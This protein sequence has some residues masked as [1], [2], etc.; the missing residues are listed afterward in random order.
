[1]SKSPSRHSKL[2]RTVLSACVAFGVRTMSP[3]SA[4]MSRPIASLNSRATPRG[5]C[6][7]AEK[8]PG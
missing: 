4:P 5:Q 1:M 2:R 3:T 6:P 8:N 7:V